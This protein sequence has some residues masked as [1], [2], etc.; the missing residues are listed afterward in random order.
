MSCLLGT[1]WTLASLKPEIGEH[2]HPESEPRPAQSTP[3][4]L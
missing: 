4:Y 2:G 1:A 3:H